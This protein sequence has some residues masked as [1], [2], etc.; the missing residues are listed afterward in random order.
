MKKN[1]T[2]VQIVKEKAKELGI[3]PTK[4]ILEAAKGMDEMRRILKS[5]NISAFD[6]FMEYRN[7]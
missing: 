1:K 3:K 7:K 4:M 2:E 5:A 6:D